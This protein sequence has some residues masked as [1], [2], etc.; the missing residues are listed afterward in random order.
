MRA[1]RTSAQISICLVVLSA[2]CGDDGAPRRRGDVDGGVPRPV[3]NLEID[4][5]GDCATPVIRGDAF[6]RA[7][8]FSPAEAGT[9]VELQVLDGP[10]TVRRPGDPGALRAEAD[11]E[12]GAAEFIVECEG[13]GVVRLAASDVEGRAAIAPHILCARPSQF[14]RNCR[15]AQP[16]TP[17][18]SWRIEQ[19]AP[20][21][22]L[23]RRLAPR[24]SR[25]GDVRDTVSLKLR[26]IFEDQSKP[27]TPGILSVRVAD[28]SVEGVEIIPRFAETEPLTGEAIFNVRA[29]SV[30]GGFRLVYTATL[31]DEQLAVD[32]APFV[33]TEAPTE[34]IA[35]ECDGG[36]RPRLAFD[37]FGGLLQR[38]GGADCEIRAEGADG[39]TPPDRTRAWVLTEAGFVTPPVRRLG[40]NGRVD[41]TINAF[42][43]FPRD[44]A[45]P[46]P[47]ALDG[48]VT[49]VGITEGAEPFEDR[50]GDGVFT[51]GID[52]FDA[53]H[54]VAEPF[55]DLD[56]DGERDEG[57]SFFDT[58]GDGEWSPRNGERDG[59][60]LLWASTRLRWVGPLADD[61]ASIRL[62]CVAPHCSPTPVPGV[63][64][65]HPDHAACAGAIGY[66]LPAAEV[67]GAVRAADLNGQCVAEGGT[68]SL[69]VFPPEAARFA[70]P[71]HVPLGPCASDGA[72]D[73]PFRLH[74]KRA[75]PGPFTVALI[76][77]DR[78]AIE[79]RLCAP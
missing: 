67:V 43:D 71:V 22:E 74:L 45:P 32:S 65:V 57:E 33:I 9:A 66:L 46:G 7:R 18:G 38:R 79:R 48:L 21:G 62:D 12:T 5:D 77:D 68:G 25:L 39:G 69:A 41:F 14:E 75:G 76:F 6:A 73:V 26:L 49:I 37:A 51:D 3:G 31:D 1:L 53:R 8:V 52:G 23:G 42:D 70:A 24:G 10:A 55:V 63:H 34:R 35:I 64:D 61:E 56:D 47:S 29:G 4:V 20:T 16:P 50:D 36:L 19:L 30:P 15:S 60:A 11:V 54:D 27:L 13:Y 59:Y 2:A 72:V 78:P 44:V 17:S 58:N 28:G 40:A